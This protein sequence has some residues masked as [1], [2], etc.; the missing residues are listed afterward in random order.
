MDPAGHRLQLE[1]FEALGGQF[2]A[3][4]EAVRT[5]VQERF[6]RADWTQRNSVLVADLLPRPPSDFL[7]H[8]AIRY[9]MFVA[10]KY[11]EHEA[12]RVTGRLPDASVA[13]EDAVGDPPCMT[14][15]GSDV[16][17]SANT[18][19]HL[20]HL[21]RFEEVTGRRLSEFRT[22]VEWGGGYGNLAKLL[23]RLHG[24]S[25]TYVLFDTPVFVA[26]QWLY[27]SS[28]LGPDRVVLHS[29]RGARLAP[30][31]LNVVPI[32][33]APDL[34]VDADLFISTWALNECTPAAQDH[35]VARRWFG[36]DALLL[37]MHQGDPF[38][39]RVLDAGACPVPVGAFMP[40]QRYLVRDGR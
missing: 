37:A 13:R 8:P 6:V 16:V 20:H 32:G 33:L 27:L 2:A 10:D 35:V 28:V 19:H 14:L 1:R 15:P 21:V 38:E 24:G 7:R 39:R 18:V 34:E 4:Y 23:L 22:V 25:P 40:A 11:L 9:Q 26:V 3:R 17:T 31:L 12:P 29:D 36:A 30:G 5:H